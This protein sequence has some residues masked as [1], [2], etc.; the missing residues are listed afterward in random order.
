[1]FSNE[2]PL[3]EPLIDVEKPVDGVYPCCICNYCLKCTCLSISM[4]TIAN[5]VTYVLCTTCDNFTLCIDCFMD[6][7]KYQHHPAHEFL[8]KNQ[9]LFDNSRRLA[10]V[11][12]RL[13]PGRGLRHRAHC[14]ECK[15]VFVLIVNV[16][17]EEHCWGQAQMFQVS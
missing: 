4:L 12:Q 1:M 8:L 7:K 3:P 15:Q 11:I 10:D 9:E 14:D 13:G 5:V 2:A 16:L 6:D 17:I